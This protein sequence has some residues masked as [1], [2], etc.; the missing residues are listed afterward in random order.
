M[1]YIVDMGNY[2][3]NDYSKLHK[4]EMSLEGKYVF[5]FEAL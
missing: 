1:Y 4:G 3:I 2:I 5:K